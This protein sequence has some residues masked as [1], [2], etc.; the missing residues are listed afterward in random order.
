MWVKTFFNISKFNKCLSSLGAVADCTMQ[1]VVEIDIYVK[2]ECFYYT[3]QGSRTIHDLRQR[4]PQIAEH[5]YFL[6]I[7]YLYFDFRSKVFSTQITSWSP[8]FP[9]M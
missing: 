5:L 8:G 2:L 4:Q 1:H 6:L 3:K 7:I 9:D